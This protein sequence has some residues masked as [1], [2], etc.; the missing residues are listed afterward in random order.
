MRQ[1]NKEAKIWCLENDG[2]SKVFLEIVD[3]KSYFIYV[4]KMSKKMSTYSTGH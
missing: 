4:C 1:N 3:K 2:T